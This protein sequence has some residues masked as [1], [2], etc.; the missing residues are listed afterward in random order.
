MIILGVKSVRKLLLW[1]VRKELLK[2]GMTRGFGGWRL[3]KKCC[4]W[5]VLGRGF[6]SEWWSG[7]GRNLGS[8]CGGGMFRL[9][10]SQ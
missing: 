3:R 5:S 7:R 8:M 6:I 10:S 9:N 2:I 4:V 1:L